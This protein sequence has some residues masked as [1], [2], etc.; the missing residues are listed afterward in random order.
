MKSVR[1]RSSGIELLRILAMLMV[2]TLHRMGHDTLNS[3]VQFSPSYYILWFIENAS[4]KAV[5]IFLSLQV[6]LA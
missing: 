4:Y 1:S 2:I 3:A 6:I 5:D